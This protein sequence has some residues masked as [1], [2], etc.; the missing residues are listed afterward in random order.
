MNRWRLPTKLKLIVGIPVLCAVTVA[1]AGCLELWVL[2]RA[3]LQMVKV[4]SHGVRLVS[5]LRT[6]LQWTR[7]L[8]F[9]AVLSLD[10]KKSEAFADDAG[11]QARKVDEA[12]RVLS[13]LIDP[14]PSS[15]ER[16]CVEQFRVAWE[17]YRQNRERTLQLAVANS[18]DKAHRLTK[19]NLADKIREIDD[20]TN[21]WTRQLDRNLIELLTAKDQSRLVEAVKSRQALGRLQVIALDLHCQLTQ[22]VFDTNEEDMNQLAEHVAIGLKEADAR[23]AELASQTGAQDAARLDALSGAFRAL[24]P[25]V[26]QMQKLLRANTGVRAEEML[27]GSNPHIDRCLAA[28][29]TLDDS[30]DGQLQTDMTGVQDGSRHAQWLM[31]LTSFAGI[32]L[33]IIMGSLVGR[34]IVREIRAL[35]QGIAGSATELS[36]VARQ[37]LTQSEQTAVQAGQVASATEQTATNINTMAAATEE[38]SMNVASISSASEQI[39]VN[40]HTISVAAEATTRN[41]TAVVEAIQNSTRTFEAIAHDAGEG[42]KIAKRAVEVAD[43]AG[44]TIK[45]LARSAAEI[46]H[47]TEAIKLLALQTNLLA[48]NATIEATSAG[49]AGKGFVVVAHEIKELAN[50]SAAAAEGIARK[51]D[52]VQSNTREAVADIGEVQEI[53]CTLNTASVR[54]SESVEQQSRSAK[55]SA[56]N[57]SQASQG[58]E[59]IAQSIA[60]VAK[61]A[62]DMSRNASEAATGANDMSRNASEAV[63]A[64]NDISN[65][66][67]GISQATRDNTTSAQQVNTAAARLASIAAQLQELVG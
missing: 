51:V 40:V 52:E 13:E 41:V 10:D 59:H 60:E 14:R 65:N 24:G 39:S 36:A 48:L 64:V 16:I 56:G 21:A 37:V 15:A 43:G 6:H 9:R 55:T 63:Q 30:L 1:V 11:A 29:A 22:Q 18:N 44:N 26:A 38:M 47:V 57:L 35:S 33:A 46:G 62:N 5:D 23:L 67:H 27:R 17:A 58:V 25:L 19:G 20:T 42:S 45:A 49:E 54:T 61:G 31:I 7:R 2:N 12:Y 34:R 3:V 66:I 53:I 28:L 32:F 8:E 4:T 50:Q